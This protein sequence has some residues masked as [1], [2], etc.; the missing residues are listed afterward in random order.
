MTDLWSSL[1]P[2]D[3][4]RVAAEALT[5]QAKTAENM[6]RV[7][8]QLSQ[9]PKLV[10][11]YAGDAGIEIDDTMQDEETVSDSQKMDQYV[12]SMLEES[13]TV[14]KDGELPK[15]DNAGIEVRLRKLEEL[16]GANKRKVNV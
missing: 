7:M 5:G 13:G 8:E 15:T 10:M 3:K 12:D 1:S 4:K 14:E 16:V 6:N 9:N 2:E 11:R